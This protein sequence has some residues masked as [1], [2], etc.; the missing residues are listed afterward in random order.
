MALGGAVFVAPV[1]ARADVPDAVKVHV[2]GDSDVVIERSIENTELWESVC[3]GACDKKLP[4]EGRYRVLGRGIRQSLPLALIEPKKD[5][6]RLDVKTAYNAG[7]VG[8]ITLVALG[9]SVL[10]AGT[11]TTA[12]GAT[13]N[14]NPPCFEFPCPPSDG[15]V[16]ANH[17]A[18]IAGVIMLGVGTLMVAAGI[19]SLGVSSQTRV[20]P[21][22]L[23][24]SPRGVRLTF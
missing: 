15:S 17:P 9:A 7:W 4:L 2:Q 3:V 8:G 20:V 22:A 23:D 12:V 13:Q 24:V 6:L 10:F 14:T 18:T 16:P 19:I 5:T 11:I 1:C 21:I